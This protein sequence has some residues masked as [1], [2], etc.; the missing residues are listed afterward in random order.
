M[1][2]FLKINRK[3]CVCVCGGG[4]G[5]VVVG[6]RATKGGGEG[7]A[8]PHILLESAVRDSVDCI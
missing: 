2:S 8:Y 4:G 5:E 6:R 7:R 1:F 3:V